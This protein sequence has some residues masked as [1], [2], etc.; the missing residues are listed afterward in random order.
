M[1]GVWLAKGPGSTN[2]KTTAGVV[3]AVIS[4]EELILFMAKLPQ[5]CTGSGKTLAY[6]I[7]TF[8][9][10]CRTLNNDGVGRRPGTD[11]IA[12][13][14]VVI[15]PTRELATQIHEVFGSY[16]I[17]AA[18]ADGA[19]CLIN[20]LG[21]QLCVGGSDAK[22]AAAALRRAAA[23]E[24][25]V[26]R[27]H[28]VSATPGRLRALAALSNSPLNLKALE[29]LVFD[30]ADRL[31]QLGFSIDV[32]AVLSAV[33]KQRRTGLFS[34]TLTTE[35]QRIMKTG[36]RNPVH[37]CVRLKRPGQGQEATQPQQKLRKKGPEAITDAP[38]EDTAPQNT[39]DIRPV[40]S[41]EL[42]TKLSNYF[43]QMPATER[44]GFLRH[45]LRAPEV[46]CSKTIVFFLTCASVDYFHVLLRELVDGRS[47]AKVKARSRK[48]APNSSLRIEKLHG[49]MEATARAKAYE[50]FCKSPAEDGAVLLATDVAA[51]GIDVDAVKWIVQ[52]DPPT[53]PAAFVHRIGRTARAGQSGR[54]VVLL[55]PHEDGYLPFLEKRG[56]QLEELPEELRGPGPGMPNFAETT[57]NRCKRMVETDR[58]VMLKSTKAFLS[59]ARAYQEHQLP[60]LFPFKSLD[61][62]NLATGYCL[63]RLPR[64]KEILGKHVKGFRQSQVGDLYTLLTMSFSFVPQTRL[65]IVGM[66]QKDF[67]SVARQGQSRSSAFPKPETGEATTGVRAQSTSVL[68]MQMN[69]CSLRRS[70]QRREKSASRIRSCR[71]T[72]VFFGHQDNTTCGQEEEKKAQLARAKQALKASLEQRFLGKG[73]A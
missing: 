71:C 10:L 22:A 28:V 56:I 7:P 33:P 9:I 13:G 36:M 8:E 40:T 30:E 51:R 23:A 39:E 19:E 59:F 65:G 31:L 58:A 15:A 73:A 44:L 72:R 47:G 11:A 61:I 34:A 17:S 60:F 53:D 52:V 54:A 16:L 3:C 35:L 50:K 1:I 32:E 63:L 37:V 69:F 38:V 5:A 64:I 26:P 24:E 57:L 12:V 25:D 14:A 70:W 43:L 66:V 67:G 6:L 4:C 49:Q 27:L 18:K 48:G 45:F 41:H 2:C 42:P 55:L 20:K 68:A 21:R 46:R 62:G 29:F